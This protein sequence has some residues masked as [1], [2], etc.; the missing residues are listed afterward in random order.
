MTKN[1]ATASQI[2]RVFTDVASVYDMM[3]DFMS[4]GLHHTWKDIFV[5]KIPLIAS[6]DGRPLSCLDMASGTGDIAIRLHQRLVRKN[7]RGKITVC[8]KNENMLSK[9]RAKY[10]HMPWTWVTSDATCL[11]L[12]D[13]CFDLYAVSF[14]LRNMPPLHKTL[15]EAH[16]V[17]KPGGY[18][19][20][21]EF[22]QPTSPFLKGLY[23]LYS[24]T[25]LPFLGATLVEKAS[26]Y[27]YLVDSIEQF[28]KAS[29]LENMIGDAGFSKT[30][31]E[32]LMGGIVT[33]HW[34]R[35]AD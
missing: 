14:G 9:G 30:R 33:I 1:T 7:I 5:E 15:R 18:F 34:G 11:S 3:N 23:D 19:C 8:D 31:F 4:F 25:W 13:N 27:N 16:R 10:K 26:A 21:L 20:V 22:S 29:I 17:L 32:P 28:P 2:Q 35:K 12:D 24:K 6:S